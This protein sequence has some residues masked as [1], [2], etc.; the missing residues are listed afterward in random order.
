[1]RARSD[2][3]TGCPDAAR[4][5]TT[6]SPQIVRASGLSV[7][8]LGSAAAYHWFIRN[9]ARLPGLAFRHL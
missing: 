2:S 4:Y 6:A 7:S 8:S 9:M 1:M 3:A 5:I